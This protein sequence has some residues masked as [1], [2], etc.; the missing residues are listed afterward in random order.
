[1]R[2]RF[3][4]HQSIASGVARRLNA[5]RGVECAVNSPRRNPY[6]E[7]PATQNVRV[8]LK[9]AYTTDY[10]EIKKYYEIIPVVTSYKL[11]NLV[12]I[13]SR[14]FFDIH[15]VASERGFAESKASLVA[16]Y[17]NTIKFIDKDSKVWVRFD[18]PTYDFDFGKKLKELY[19]IGCCLGLVPNQFLSPDDDK[20]KTT[21]KKK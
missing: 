15:G 12:V 6:D 11:S 16:R 4:V 7:E 13:L 3:T 1:M 14:S 17:D 19:K 21:G 9:T 10:E 18:M 8:K 2:I 20:P 5:I